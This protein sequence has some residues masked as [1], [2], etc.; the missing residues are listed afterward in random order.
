MKFKENKE[1]A[2][3]IAH[4]PAGMVKKVLRLRQLVIDTARK[5]SGVDSLEEN[6]KWGEPSFRSNIGSPVRIAW[7]SKQPDQYALYVSCS[8]NLVAAFKSIYKDNLEYEGKRAIVFKG[9]LPLKEV[10]HCIALA[11]TYHKRKHIPEVWGMV[12]PEN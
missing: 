9:K 2:K 10:K 5:T 7:N 3:V 1:V 8:T 6:L 11:L 4:Y 12:G